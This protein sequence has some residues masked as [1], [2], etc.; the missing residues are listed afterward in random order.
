M[1]REALDA[2]RAEASVWDQ[3]AS[4]CND[5]I[6]YKYDNLVCRKTANGGYTCIDPWAALGAYVS[7]VNPC[8]HNRPLRDA[9]WFKELYTE[10]K[11]EIG[12]VIQKFSVSGNQDAEDLA[13]EWRRFAHDRPLHISYAI[14]VMS[15]KDMANIGKFMEASVQRDTGGPKLVA[16]SEDASAKPRSDSYAAVLKRQTRARAKTRKTRQ[17]T[18]V[19]ANLGPASA[20]TPSSLTSAEELS[21]EDNPLFHLRISCSYLCSC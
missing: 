5:Y 12:V 13:T 15:I 21:Y 2:Q 19:A 9:T 1:T 17:E 6:V 16:N 20:S 11:S 18:P 10:I 8:D 7:S 3:L 4:A 14:A